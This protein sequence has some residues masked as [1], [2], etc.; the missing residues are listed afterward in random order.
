MSVK[1]NGGLAEGL[2]GFRVDERVESCGDNFNLFETG[3]TEIAGYPTRAALDI[4]L[5]LALGADAGNAQKLKQFRE[6]LVA[7]TINKVS[8]IHKK[9]S[10]DRSPFQ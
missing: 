4:G 7:A 3:G 8:K 9:P 5:V 10:R 2:Q 1:E 6:M